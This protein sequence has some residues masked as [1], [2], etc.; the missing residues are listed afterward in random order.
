ME[1]PVDDLFLAD[2]TIREPGGM[3]TDS[4]ASPGAAAASACT[5]THK[6]WPPPPKA[7]ARPAPRRA[8]FH[9]AITESSVG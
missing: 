7:P 2:T 3:D 1:D 4:G 6:S 8:A 9:R 5:T